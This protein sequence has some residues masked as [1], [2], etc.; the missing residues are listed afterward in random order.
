MENTAKWIHEKSS[1][2]R[3][4]FKTMNREI[5]EIRNSLSLR[6]AVLGDLENSFFYLIAKMQAVADIPTWLGA[7]EKAI[8]ENPKDDARAVAIA[9]QAVIDAQGSGHVK[10]LADVQRGGP[11][12]KLWT[13]FYSYFSTTYNLTV[14]SVK[15]T[16]WKKPA[17]VGMLAADVFMLYVIPVAVGMALKEAVKGGG[18]D[19]DKDLPTRIANETAMYI[20]GTMVGLR[21]FGSAIQGFRGYQGPPG[22]RFFAE[23]GQLAKQVQQGEADEAFWKA[24]NK[25]AGILFHYP[26]GQVDRTVRGFRA[27]QEG[28]A[29]PGALLFGPPMKR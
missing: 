17:S 25:T 28:D 14:R 26:A 7:Y 29:G 12:K 11:L 15:R 23:A 18:D 8:A 3:L 16:D 20:L 9:D 4:R 5:G 24:A 10:D 21:E 2:M 6:G 27:L 19:D 22:T 1:F 13:S